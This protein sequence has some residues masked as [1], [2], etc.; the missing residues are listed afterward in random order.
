MDI[1]G[2]TGAILDYAPIE[3]LRQLDKLIIVDLT[4]SL[5]AK[6][7]EKSRPVRPDQCGAGGDGCL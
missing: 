6:A 2:G 3:R 1:G 5:L 4:P 7:R